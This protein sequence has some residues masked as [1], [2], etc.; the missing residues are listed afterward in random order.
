MADPAALAAPSDLRPARGRWLP[1]EWPLVFM[2]AG[3]PLWWVLGAGSVIWPLFAVPMAGRLLVRPAAIRVPKG[4]GWWVL[5]LVWMLLSAVSLSGDLPVPFLW[6]VANYLSATVTFVYIYNTPRERLPGPRIVNL[7]AGFWMMTVLGGWLGVAVPHGELT[8]VVERLLPARLLSYEFVQLLVHPVFAQVQTVLGY[9]L[10]RPTAPFLYTNDWGSVYAL[11]IPFFILGWLQS[12]SVSRRRV[13]PVLLAVSIVPALLSLNRGLWV[14]LLI[15]LAFGAS[16][17][18]DVGRLARRSLIA[19]VVVG[20]A[21]VA[22]TPLR[23]VVEGRAENQHSNEGREFLYVE[24]T[25]AVLDSPVIGYGGPRPYGGSKIIPNMGTQGQF[26]LVLFSQGIPGAILFVGFL[27]KMWRATRHGP[28]ITFWCHVTLTIALLQMFVY[29]M[30]PVQL[31]LI[32]IVAAL[33]CREAEVDLRHRA[34]A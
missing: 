5:F 29:D 34:A 23:S 2:L 9:P 32:F 15:A 21:L 13:A 24:T 27:V 19:I 7:L 20:L 25:K 10:G 28:L 30:V 6:R 33:G 8:T 16:R 26:W 18:G 12:R 11:T 22:F 4:F 14:S 17:P 1:P 31:H 3:Y